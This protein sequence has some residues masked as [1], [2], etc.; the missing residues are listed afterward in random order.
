MTFEEAS[1]P[2]EDERGPYNEEAC[3]A[4]AKEVGF[5]RLYNPQNLIPWEDP[6]YVDGVPFIEQRYKSEVLERRIGI[7][8]Q[9][10]TDK[11][12]NALI[13]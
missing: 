6:R 13:T 9:Q 11:A 7:E 1:I 12:N 4:W 8:T 3:K 2:M 5:G 10:R